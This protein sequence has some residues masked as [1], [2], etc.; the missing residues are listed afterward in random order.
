MKFDHFREPGT[1]EIVETHAAPVP[2]IVSKWIYN[3]MA[4]VSFTR[5]TLADRQSRHPESK[6]YFQAD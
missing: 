1:P 2:R 6:A 5:Q 3:N 4:G